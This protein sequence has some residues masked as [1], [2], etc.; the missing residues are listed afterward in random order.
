MES[1]VPAHTRAFTY[2]SL[3]GQ[4]PRLCISL[5]EKGGPSSGIAVGV[6]RQQRRG[7]RGPR[8]TRRGFRR[9]LTTGHTMMPPP[10]R[11]SYLHHRVVWE[12]KCSVR[13]GM[14]HRMGCSITEDPSCFRIH[15]CCL[16]PQNSVHKG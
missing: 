1:R 2:S 14:R 11:E 3:G 8:C 6:A 4:W 5:Q 12:A 10:H 16:I 9:T 13:W 7:S 15:F